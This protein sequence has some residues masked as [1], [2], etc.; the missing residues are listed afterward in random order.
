MLGVS[1]TFKSHILSNIQWLRGPFQ[2]RM[3]QIRIALLR[4]FAVSGLFSDL[5]TPGGALPES[6]LPGAIIGRRVQGFQ[7]AALQTVGIGVR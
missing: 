2:K 3:P 7:F 5:I 4:G 1:T 6:R